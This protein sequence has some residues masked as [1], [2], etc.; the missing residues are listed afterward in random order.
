MKGVKMAREKK[1]HKFL[2]FILVIAILAIAA[3]IFRLSA[4]DNVKHAV[5]EKATK[6]AITKTVE[7]VASTTGVSVDSKEI[8]EKIDNMEEGDK[9]KLNEIIDEN[10]TTETVTDISSYV[11]SGDING[12]KEYIQKNLPDKDINELQ[13]LSDKYLKGEYGDIDLN[14]LKK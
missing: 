4:Y 2:N 1:S 14:S 5:K 13:K 8:E 10:V 9:E 3:V 11:S 12:A 6:I 7:K